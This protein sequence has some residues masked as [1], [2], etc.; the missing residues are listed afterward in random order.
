MS[1]C[2]ICSHPAHTGRVCESAITEDIRDDVGIFAR[3]TGLT[4]TMVVGTCKCGL[5][6]LVMEQLKID[7]KEIYGLTKSSPAWNLAGQKGT[8]S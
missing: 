5:V 8:R 2:T 4:R 3:P 7:V 1:D 6:D